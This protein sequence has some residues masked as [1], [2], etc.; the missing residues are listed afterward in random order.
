[1]TTTPSNIAANTTNPVN[2]PP[3]RADKAQTPARRTAGATGRRA[4]GAPGILLGMATL[5]IAT[6]TPSISRTAPRP[7]PAAVAGE[8]AHARGLAD[9]GGVVAKNTA[10]RGGP[11]AALAQDDDAAADK[12]ASPEQIEKY[13]AVY[14]AMQR[15]HSMTIE[16]A[17][18]TQGM[19]VSAFRQL[20]QRITRDDLSRDAARRALAAPTPS[21][22]PTAKA[23][24]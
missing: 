15:N 24:R 3:A 16:Q 18:A 8:L 19:T 6:L 21:A 2:R 22:A 11:T 5:G 14:R 23:P 20:E 9:D 4:V 17:A 1:M 10:S 12:G 13:V 7:E